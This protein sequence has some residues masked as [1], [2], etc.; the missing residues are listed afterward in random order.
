MSSGRAGSP[1]R[2]GWGARPV[3]RYVRGVREFSLPLSA[4]S[5]SHALYICRQVARQLGLWG[6]EVDLITQSV[7]G[8]T[9]TCCSLL[10]HKPQ[11]PADTAAWVR[12]RERA[13]VS[14]YLFDG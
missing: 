8:A 3:R 13:H 11:P 12:E 7:Q 4:R 1:S 6:A 14:A 9:R 5:S 10:H 2:S